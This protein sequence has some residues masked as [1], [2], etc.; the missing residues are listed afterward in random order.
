M[1]LFESKIDALGVTHHTGGL[2]QILDNRVKKLVQWPVPASVTEVRAF[3]GATGITRRWVKNY[4]EM[5]RPLSRLT[6]NAEW[7]WGDSEQLFFD[8]LRISCALA[9]LMNG[10]DFREAVEMYLDASGFAAGLC[11]VQKRDIGAKTSIEVSILYDAFTFNRA[12]VKYGTYK[13][14][15]CAMVTFARK[16]SYL[17]RHS[18]KPGILYTDHKPLVQFLD[19]E[20][21]DG[22][23]GIWAATLRELHVT[24]HYIPGPRNMVADGLSRTIFDQ[25][26]CSDDAKVQAIKKELETKGPQWI[27]KD[28]KGGY[29]DFLAKLME[30]EADEVIDRGTLH[31]AGVFTRL[32]TARLSWEGA[33]LQSSWFGEIYRFL[34]T[35]TM[36]T[37]PSKR[38]LRN[39][40]DYRIENGLL[41]VF[42]KGIHVLCVPEQHVVIV[43]C[44]VYDNSGY[45]A[46]DM[47]MF[48]L[49]RQAFWPKQ[50][51]DVEIYVR[52]CLYCARHAYASRNQP[53]I[54]YTL[55][56]PFQLGL[57][58]FIGLLQPTKLGNR[59]IFHY[60]EVF[61]RFSTAYAT[62]TANMGDAY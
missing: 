14:E 48:K 59:Y 4:S 16:Y 61:S 38:F 22:I 7:R 62:K 33:Y 18:V 24:I 39:A 57:M 5:A 28:G 46:K 44:E 9:L 58:D 21:H 41:W 25:P 51:I 37:A 50:S 6:G 19:S 40:L 55:K 45:W 15:L 26:D 23:Y 56:M 13:R 47:T 11:V 30:E 42:Y 3:L 1:K 35:G 20:L 31:E 2:V 43:L 53:L 8:L 27:W 17:L 12:E 52:G 36:P 34:D 29:Q 54:F 49:K 32:N 60:M 10:I